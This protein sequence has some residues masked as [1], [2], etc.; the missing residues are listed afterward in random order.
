MSTHDN[1][2][3][4]LTLRIGAPFVDG[5]ESWPDNRFEFRVF[6]GH[7]M[8]QLC[9]AKLRK[10]DLKA[11]T[12]GKIYTGLYIR[13]EFLALLF[14]IESLMDWS[15]QV[16]NI[17]LVKEEDSQAPQ[18]IPGTHQVM[19]I[20]LIEATTGIVKAIRVVTFSKHATT[21]LCRTLQFQLQ[22]P[23]DPE[24]HAQ[25]VAELYRRYPNSKA[26]V[27]A[28]TVTERAGSQE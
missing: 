23:F 10:K 13:N 16:V 20:I 26:L 25:A 8:L 15:D 27:K 6:G 4:G 9:L 14:K 18:N 22:A 5:V 28:A 21:L 7:V 11:F 3:Q 17:N 12:E 2:A 24:L 19:S 1:P